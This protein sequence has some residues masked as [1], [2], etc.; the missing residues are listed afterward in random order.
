M[1][2]MFGSVNMRSNENTVVL[3]SLNYMES[4]EIDVGMRS[5]LSY[6]Q[7]R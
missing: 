1:C 6:S 2:S 3:Y 7:V 5:I 4:Y